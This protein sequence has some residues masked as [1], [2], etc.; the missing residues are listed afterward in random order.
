MTRRAALK[1]AIMQR[2]SQQIDLWLN[3][4]QALTCGYGNETGVHESGAKG[5]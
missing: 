2:L 1:E 3:Q 4:Q 5:R